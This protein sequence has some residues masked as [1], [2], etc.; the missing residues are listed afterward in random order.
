MHPLPRART[1]RPL[2][3]ALA[4]ILAAAGIVPAASAQE[5]P[6]LNPSPARDHRG[7]LPLAPGG[8]GAL[9][10]IVPDTTNPLP[11]STTQKLLSISPDGVAYRFDAMTAALA[12][13]AP[14]EIIVAGPCAAAPDGFLRRATSISQSGGD[15]IVQTAQ[16]TLE[17]ALQ[18]GEVHMETV[19]L[20]GDIRSVTLAEGVTARAAGQSSNPLSFHLDFN[21]VL[22]QEGAAIVR[23]SGSVDIAPRLSFDLVVRDWKVRQLAATA[24]IDQSAVVRV[25]AALE[26]EVTESKVLA[27]YYLGAITFFV[28]PVPVVVSP[29]LQISVGVT[30]KVHIGVTAQISQSASLT[31]GARYRDG[32]GWE[33][34]QAIVPGF[35]S[36]PPSLEA[37]LSIKGFARADIDLRLYGVAGWSVGVSPYLELVADIATAP[38]WKLHGGIDVPVGVEVATL[39]HSFADFYKNVI[40]LKQLLRLATSPPPVWDMLQVPAGAFTMGC[41]PDHN[42]GYACGTDEQPLHAVTLAAFRIDKTEVT[43][44]QYAQCVAGGACTPP[45]TAASWTR[46]SYYGDP[47]FGDYPVIF[48][49]WNQADAFCRWRGA[50]L[51]TEAEWEKA[52][53]GAI[54]TRAFPW[55]DAAP[56]CSL[57]NGYVGGQCVG[58]TSAAGGYPS[59][60][61]PYG[62]LGM[63]GN[64]FE[65]VN[66]WYDSGYYAGSPAAD[67]PGPATGSFKVAR[68]GGY[69]SY[70]GYLRVAYRWGVGPSAQTRDIGFRCASD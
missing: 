59:G 63:A 2:F 17:D 35:A 4:L 16:A 1:R 8:A 3:L 5:G 51:P 14:G 30:G 18:Q 19:M 56:T 34:I 64:V 6:G 53:R 68:G 7:Y 22:V 41:D 42:G 25:D 50:R 15:V 9:P 37:T 28:G 26:D 47:A 52:A 62:A 10:P 23:A 61:S 21:Q 33:T 29:L 67:P 36:Q 70:G 60:A 24:Y 38:W 66:D 20:P 55:G 13:V 49:S 48:V 12:A 46:A 58:D 45:S 39:G 44:A 43:N 57:M 32:A 31:A 27:E 65:W 11:A 54:G 69:T 40:T